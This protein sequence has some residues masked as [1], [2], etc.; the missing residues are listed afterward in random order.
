[1]DYLGRR[2]LFSPEVYRA[3]PWSV[4]GADS[5]DVGAIATGATG[6]PAVMF[7]L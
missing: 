5:R 3:D 2:L 6:F 4:I 7:Y 1:M